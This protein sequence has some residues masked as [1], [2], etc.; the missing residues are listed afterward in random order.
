MGHDE[1]VVLKPLPEA[2]N[3]FPNFIAQQPETIVL[4]EKISLSGDSFSVKTQDGR[5]ILQVKGEAMSL[6]GRK[7]FMDME[8]KVL[9]QLRKQ[10]FS[11]PKTFYCED[12]QGAR[13]LEVQCKFGSK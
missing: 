13:I 1:P 8:G 10:H 3:L 4:K 11:I 9:F 5:P 7:T 12:S 6:S 2:I